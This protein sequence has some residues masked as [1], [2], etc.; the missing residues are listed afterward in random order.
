MKF[1]SYQFIDKIINALEEQFPRRCS[2]GKEFENLKDFLENTT[3]PSLQNLQIF[4]CEH[5]QEIL[6][7]RN[8]NNCHSTI[9]VRCALNQNDKKTLLNSIK[10]DISNNLLK[11]D[12]FLILFRDQVLKN[13]QKKYYIANDAK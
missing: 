4:D 11:E 13:I 1:K 10:E 8:C 6:A 2:C 12:E 5:T 9:S 7:L 3:L